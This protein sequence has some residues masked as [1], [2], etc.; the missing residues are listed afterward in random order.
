M[1]R[2]R[3]RKSIRLK[4]YDYSQAG[5]YFVKICTQNHE[6]KFGNIVN[7]EMH[8]NDFGM[9]VEDCWKGIPLHFKNV[10]LDEYIIMPNH[11]HGILILNESVGHGMPCPYQNSSENPF[12]VPFPRL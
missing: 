9:V 2:K 8:L 3:Q 11:L 1:L 12:Q 7:G 10:E 4:E 5:E 6:C